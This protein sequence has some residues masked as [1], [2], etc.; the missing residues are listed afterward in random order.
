[1]FIIIEKRRPEMPFKKII[2]IILIVVFAMSL[3]YAQDAKKRDDSKYSCVNVML[4]K[5]Y[6]TR[7]GLI[8]EYFT[9]NQMRQTYLPNKF[10]EQGMAIKVV[11]NDQKTTPQM[12]V[13]YK[14]LQPYKVKIY[15]PLAQ[16]GLTYQ[17]IEFM[18]KEQ[19]D[20]FT[21][22]DKLV[23]NFWDENKDKAKK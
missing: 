7:V 11:D 17:I 22:A 3:T 19:E 5:V 10:F 1:M 13:M 15:M 4:S 6:F 23:F 2:Y 9:G 18:T 14:D 12:N 21:N 16:D 8:L 20:K